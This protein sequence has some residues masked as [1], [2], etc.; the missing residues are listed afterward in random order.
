MARK[1]HTGNQVHAINKLNILTSV[2]LIKVPQVSSGTD[3]NSR[4]TAVSE[5]RC[6]CGHR[7]PGH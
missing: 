1:Q 7:S 6:Q 5:H 4:L 3:N 2:A